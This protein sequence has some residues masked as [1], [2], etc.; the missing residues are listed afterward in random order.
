[1]VRLELTCDQ[2]LFLRLI[3]LR[4]YISMLYKAE[5]RRFE[6]LVPNYGTSVQQTDA[7][8]RSAILPIL[9]RE[10][11]S[12]PRKCDPQRFSR[13]PHSTTL[14]SLQIFCRVDT[15][16]TCGHVVPNH[17]LYLLSYYPK[18][19]RISKNRTQP[20]RSKFLRT[21][22][23]LRFFCEPTEVR[24]QDPI[25][26]RDVL[27]LL[28]YRFNYQYISTGSGTRTHTSKSDKGF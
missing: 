16:R 20:S 9:R 23:I 13:P 22:D 7:I 14:P 21:T 3:R 2:L 6:L 5:E 26:K 15:I 28:S 18:F 27:Y 24:T 4:R 12:N 1:M 8:N 11:D 10:R 25:L 17:V 19:C